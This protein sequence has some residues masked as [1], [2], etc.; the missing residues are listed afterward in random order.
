MDIEI[1]EHLS[2]FMKFYHEIIITYIFVDYFTKAVE[3]LVCMAV[4][5]TYHAPSTVRTTC[6]TYNLDT[7]LHVNLD[8]LESLVSQVYLSM[9]L[10]IY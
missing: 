6:V 4:T 10:Y 2:I 8:G 3:N 1:V 7:V 5:V 9:I